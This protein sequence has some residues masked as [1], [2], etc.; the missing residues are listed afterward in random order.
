MKK[1]L[2]N[3]LPSVRLKNIS[4]HFSKDK[5]A[6]PVIQNIS[7]AIAKGESLAIVGPS[8][9]GKTTLL[10]IING[11]TAPSQGTIILSKKHTARVFQSPTLLPWLTLQENIEIPLVL[12]KKLIPHKKEVATIIQKFGLSDFGDNYPK[13]L[14]GGMQS[15]AALARALITKPDL[16]L[17]DE[18]FASLDELTAL[19]TI[20]ELSRFLEDVCPTIIFV[21]HSLSQAILLAN[22]VIVLSARPAKI[23]ADIHIAL[24]HPRTST[25]FLT[26]NFQKIECLLR[27]IISNEFLCV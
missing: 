13:E 25:V 26:E 23:I 9:C 1:I 11:L 21:T 14:S 12:T 2:N 22:R 19:N 3:N 6:L 17:L 24:K 27:S 16:L 20:F 15:R 10:N 18:P 5:V 4:H 8:G 7:L